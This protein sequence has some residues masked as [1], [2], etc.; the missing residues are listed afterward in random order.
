MSAK[1]TFIHMGVKACSTDPP[2]R[3]RQERRVDQRFG[4]LSQNDCLTSDMLAT[5]E[6]CGAGAVAQYKYCSSLYY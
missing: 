2:S 6:G 4:A 3:L 5:V 1:A